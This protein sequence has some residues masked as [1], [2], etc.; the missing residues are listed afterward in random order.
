[1][2]KLLKPLAILLTTLLTLLSPVLHAAT[3]PTETAQ[4]ELIPLPVTMLF[5]P[6]RADPKEPRFFVSK[7]RVDS[8]ANKDTSIAAVGFGEHFGFIRKQSG[9]QQGWQLGLG[10]AVFAQFNLDTPSDDLLNADYTI[11]FPLSWRQ[12]SWSG[13]IRLYHQSSHL[14]DEYLLNQSPQRINLSFEAVEVLFARNFGNLRLYGGGENI[15]SHEPADLG[16]NILHMGFDWN[17][18]ENAFHIGRLGA[19]RWVVGVDAKRWDQNNR[20]LQL[21]AKIGLEFAPRKG[22]TTP[23]Q[24]WSL[25]LEYYDGMSPYGQFYANDVNYWGVAIQLGI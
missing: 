11:G 19:A 15:F 6:L 22:S 18:R 4:A 16:E 13:R 23:A 12:N 7:L 25:L 3:M 21:S 14:G 17:S 9:P 2:L 20:D 24:R 1:M 8:A 5:Q 10:A